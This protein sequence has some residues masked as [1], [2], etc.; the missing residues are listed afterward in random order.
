MGW[1]VTCGGKSCLALR[2]P[3]QQLGQA[4]Q[5]MRKGLGL[6]RWERAPGFQPDCSH[7]FAGSGQEDDLA[8]QLSTSLVT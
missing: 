4:A 6:S 2:K 1:A 7:R 5:P 3:F 8:A